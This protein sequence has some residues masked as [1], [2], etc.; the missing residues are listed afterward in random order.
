MARVRPGVVAEGPDGGIH[1]R[2]RPAR[3]ILSAGAVSSPHLLLLAGIGPAGRPAS[4]G[5]PGRGGRA[6]CRPRCAR[7]PQG[8]DPVAAPRR[9]RP[10]RGRAVAPALGALHRDRLGPARRHDAVPQLGGGRATIRARSTSASRR[11]TTSSGPRGACGSA[12]R[13][14]RPSRPSTCGCSSEPRD[15]AR[16]ADAVH[17]SI[18]LGGSVRSR[19]CCRH[20]V[21]PGDRPT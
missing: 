20:L 11:S 7:P 15:R 4:P 12:R 9:P 6:G 18:E 17:R 13:T 5:H 2:T 1:P 3:S 19:R 14:R 10:L 8:V 21:L 16:L